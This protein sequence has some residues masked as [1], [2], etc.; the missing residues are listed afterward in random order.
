LTL[1]IRGAGSAGGRLGRGPTERT[2]DGWAFLKVGHNGI[3]YMGWL[4]VGVGGPD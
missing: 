3:V 4:Q 2:G 1:S